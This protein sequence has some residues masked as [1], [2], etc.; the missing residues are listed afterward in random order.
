MKDK[1]LGVVKLAIVLLV[2]MSTASPSLPSN[3]SAED[4][5][6]MLPGEGEVQVAG[7]E[8][9]CEHHSPNN[10]YSC[11]C[12]GVEGN[13][14][15]WAYYK[16]PETVHWTEDQI[17]PSGWDNYAIEEGL[18]VGVIPLDKALA[19]WDWT[20]VSA[21][22]GHVAYVEN[23]SSYPPNG[24]STFHVTE[25][26]CGLHDCERHNDYSADGGNNKHFIYKTK[27]THLL[28]QLLP[29]EVWPPSPICAPNQIYFY[30]DILNYGDVAACPTFYF[31]FTKP[32]GTKVE[33][34]TGDCQHF[35]GAHE[36]VY[37]QFLV[38]DWAR[39]C[40]EAGWWTLEQISYSVPGDD[41]RYPLIPLC[42]ADGCV[43]QEIQFCILPPEGSGGGGQVA[44]VLDD[45]DCPSQYLYPTPTPT[46]PPEDCTA[47]RDVG[48][49]FFVEVVERLADVPLSD[50]AVD[51]LVLWE[52]Y[53]NTAA[54]W[55]PLAT[56]WYMGGSCDFNP[57]GVKHYL[58]QDMG[59]QA[60]ANTLAQGYYYN[61][62]R[63]LRLEEF[64]REGLRADLSVWGTCSGQG[65]NSLLN[66]WEALW[67][68]Q[69]LPS[70]KQTTNLAI[71]PETPGYGQNATFSFT[72]HNYGNG[73]ITFQK[74]G[75]SGGSPT[76]QYWDLFVGN[77]TL[78]A[79]DDYNFNNSQ[80]FFELGD[81]DAKTTY[82]SLD[83][84]WHDFP[85]EPEVSDKLYFTVVEPSPPPT[86]TPEP[87][88]TDSTPPEATLEEPSSNSAFRDTISARVRATDDYC[89][90]KKVDFY[91]R[92]DGD[93]HSASG[94]YVGDDRWT[95]SWNVSGVA[96]QSDVWAL[97]W[98]EDNAGNRSQTGAATG[99]HI[100][101][102]PPSPV[103]ITS[104]SSNSAFRS[105]IP[106]SASV[107]DGRSGPNRFEFY[108]MYSDNLHRIGVGNA[109]NSWTINWGVNDVPEQSGVTIH[110]EA[111]DNA[112]NIANDFAAVTGVAI[113]RTSPQISFASA[114]GIPISTGGQDVYSNVTN[115]TF[116]GTANDSGAGLDSIVFG[117]WGNN[118]GA[119][120]NDTV[121]T[122]SPWS[123]S[124][125][126]LLGHNRIHFWSVDKAG[127]ES[128]R[129]YIELY[130]DTA[131]PGTAAS[132]SGTM[133][134]EGWYLS[135][136]EVTLNASD[137]GSGGSGTIGG[138][139]NRFTAGIGVTSYRIDSGAWQTYSGSFTVSGDGTHTVDY[140]SVDA[141]GNEESTQS[142]TI[143]IDTNPPSGSLSINRGASTSYSLNVVLGPS[144]SD[145]SGSGVSQMRFGNSNPDW[146]GWEAYAPEKAW[147]LTDGSGSKTVYVQFQD[148]AGNTSSGYSAPIVVDLYPDRP[149]SQNY[150][151]FKSVV[152][153]GGEGKSSENYKAG[154]T[155]G[156]PAMGPAPERS[157]SSESF[158]LVTGYWAM[159]PWPLSGDFNHDCKI[160]VEDIMQVASRWRTSCAI[161]DP[162]HDVNTPNYE[163][164]YDIDRDCDID[165]VDIMKV[166]VH[167]GETCP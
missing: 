44:Q 73:P 4:P 76:D 138:I 42:D 104:P 112:G 163:K 116:E 94:V 133:G 36:W 143:K 16:R 128:A 165:I 61:I 156:Q 114:N 39:E 63:M 93:W 47:G 166:V 69:G 144:A 67:N 160:D 149:A 155:T 60:T 52:P 81:W 95:A 98:V 103:Y 164:M 5:V 27:G 33:L 26:N 127:N 12:G 122:S 3:V 66:E 74:I 126:G 87:G 125:N 152:G 70:P 23:V 147:R 53:E 24:Y 21:D 129:K 130:V 62:R 37:A 49:D 90:V 107:S 65:C 105:Y 86:P 140:Y 136:V 31:R 55:N 14:V 80:A 1:T 78:N 101:R 141:V 132:L 46:C 139:P 161:P 2:L 157:Q 15:W 19:I 120:W 35:F 117:G 64:N 102:T 17:W 151:I 45:D 153:I 11:Q 88:C 75:I 158:R 20:E 57:V 118:Y 167:W 77:V 8:D 10:P 145:G 109:D 7:D 41:R 99:I 59:A 48:R 29:T 108:A 56:T 50:F 6:T 43:E 83:G 84:N 146:S 13:C 38:E 18:P 85:I 51:A 154:N 162:D 106:L 123:Y 115:W 135:P 32:F 113:D 25:M 148:T 121:G 96:E 137:N 131:A 68:T 150:R 111:F 72:V 134:N 54:C 28:M 124:Q 30:V 58:S 110:G 40:T 159:Q 79:G 9:C 97:A 82:Q 22:H 89:G 71:S 92:Y 100:D 142:L 91:L 119:G 34:F